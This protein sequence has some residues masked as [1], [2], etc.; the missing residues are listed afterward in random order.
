L[1]VQYI[2]FNHNLTDKTN[3]NEKKTKPIGNANTNLCC[4]WPCCCR[5]CD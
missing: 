1:Y 5:T 3:Q 4:L 2:H